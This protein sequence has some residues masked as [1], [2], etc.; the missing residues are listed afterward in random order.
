MHL[1]LYNVLVNL[2]KGDEIFCHKQLIFSTTVAE[3][4][5][6]SFDELDAFTD[7]GFVNEKF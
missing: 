5:D 1:S 2:K 7:K 6:N 4:C 3:L